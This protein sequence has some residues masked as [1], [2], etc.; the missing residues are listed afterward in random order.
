MAIPLLSGN[1]T[2]RAPIK[3]ALTAALAPVDRYTGIE[4]ELIAPD[5]APL[6]SFCRRI[7][8]AIVHDGSI[9]NSLG[10]E[11]NLPPAKGVDLLN[12]VTQFHEAALASR[13]YTTEECGVHVHVDVRDL[14]PMQIKRVFHA[15]E[16]LEPGLYDML[17]G[18]RKNSRYCKRIA[19]NRQLNPVM[20]ANWH[21]ARKALLSHAMIAVKDFPTPEGFGKAKGYSPKVFAT[22]ADKHEWY[23]YFG[24][25]IASYWTHGT[26]EN[27]LPAGTV[28]GNDI[29]GWALLSAAIVDRAA[30][31]KTDEFHLLSGSIE[32]VVSLAPTAG[33]Q[34]WAVS[35]YDKFKDSTSDEEDTEEE[36]N[37]GA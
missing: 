16:R 17:P 12:V 1:M 35:Q 20:D 13:A 14:R 3:S 37:D 31:M 9:H 6:A 33:L 28:D 8:A 25:N 22:R 10:G 2:P 34:R 24:L 18:H 4:I 36:A 30:K 15:W 27:R 11:I 21:T 23:R 5:W 19:Q 26:V 29:L 7:G 32:G